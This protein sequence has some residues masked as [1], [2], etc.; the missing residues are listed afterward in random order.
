MDAPLLVFG[1]QERGLTVASGFRAFVM[2]T[3]SDYLCGA[4]QARLAQDLAGEGLISHV[5]LWRSG[6]AASGWV[7][8]LFAS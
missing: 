8:Q 3:G 4:A 7:T 5:C 2:H 6:G 1:P